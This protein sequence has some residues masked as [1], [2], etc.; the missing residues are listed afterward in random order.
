[1]GKINRLIVS[2]NIAESC[3]NNRNSMNIIIVDCHVNSTDFTIYHGTNMVLGRTLI[4]VMDYIDALKD[5]YMLRHALF[6][7]NFRNGSYDT[8]IEIVARIGSVIGEFDDGFEHILRNIFIGVW[9]I[10]QYVSDKG[11]QYND[12]VAFGTNPGNI[13]FYP[14]PTLKG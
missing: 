9:S 12:S 7:E 4:D 10:E 2:T 8:R 3:T 14:S 11:K 5:E 6:L 13:G 1:M